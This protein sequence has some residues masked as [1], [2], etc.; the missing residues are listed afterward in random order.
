M[1]DKKL[2]KKLSGH[3]LFHSSKD[4]DLEYD[5]Y[6]K[7]TANMDLSIVAF[8]KVDKTFREVH[9]DFEGTKAMMEFGS[10]RKIAYIESAKHSAPRV[11]TDYMSARKANILK[12]AER[13]GFKSYLLGYLAHENT[14]LTLTRINFHKNVLIG[15]DT[16]VLPKEGC[17]AILDVLDKE[18]KG[19]DVLSV[20]NPE[21]E[22]SVKNG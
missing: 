11:I 19:V 18:F 20:L 4:G 21:K 14:Y 16:L 3:K 13:H 8:D 22:E 10:D 1:K 17:K 6:Y 2:F 12:L 5:F 9:L 15:M 7:F